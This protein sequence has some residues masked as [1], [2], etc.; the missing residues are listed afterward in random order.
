M[1]SLIWDIG[2][3]TWRPLRPRISKNPKPKNF[4]KKRDEN[5]L[6]MGNG[7]RNLRDVFFHVYHV[8]CEDCCAI[9]DQ[10]NP[11]ICLVHFCLVIVFDHTDINGCVATC[12]ACFI[13]LPQAAVS[14]KLSW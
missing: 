1:S 6:A 7:P 8:E 2:V 11:F 14:S 10:Q 13:A 4:D 3:P 5:G 12:G 9:I